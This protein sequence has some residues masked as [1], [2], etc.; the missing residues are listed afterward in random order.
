MTV[1]DDD[2]VRTVLRASGAP[3]VPLTADEVRLLQREIDRRYPGLLSPPDGDT[4]RAVPLVVPPAVATAYELAAYPGFRCVELVQPSG[5][6]HV[7][8]AMVAF[9]DD[10]VLA[11]VLDD[12]GRA[13]DLVDRLAPFHAAD[14]TAVEAYLRFRL[15]S[16]RVGGR[17]YHLAD[18]AGSIAEAFDDGRHDELAVSLV[19]VQDGR[20]PRRATVGL[21][22]RPGEGIVAAALPGEP[23]LVKDEPGAPLVPEH[24]GR[25]ADHAAMRVPTPPFVETWDHTWRPAPPTAASTPD[26]GSGEGV[27]EWAA[28]ADLLAGF[29]IGAD[30]GRRTIIRSLRLPFYRTFRLFEVVAPAPAGEADP[31]LGYCLGRPKPGASSS[32]ELRHLDGTATPIYDANEATDSEPGALVELCLE[33]PA[34]E[35]LIGSAEDRVAGYVAFFCWGIEAAAGQFLVPARLDHLELEAV[36]STELREEVGRRG[37]LPGLR[38]PFGPVDRLGPFARE[39]LVVHGELVA[40]ASFAVDRDGL[41]AM[42]GDEP[43]GVVAA[44]TGSTRAE[45]RLGWDASR[46]GEGARPAPEAPPVVPEP[47]ALEVERHGDAVTFRGGTFDDTT[48][49]LGRLEGVRRATFEG[50]WFPRGLDLRGR[51]VEP[52]VELV[53]CRFGRAEGEGAAVDLSGASF[54]GDLTFHDCHLPGG[55]TGGGAT[56][57]GALQVLSC[58]LV[59][60]PPTSAERFGSRAGNP[61]AGSYRAS[62]ADGAALDLTGVTVHGNLDVGRSVHSWART[63]VARDV[64]LARARVGGDLQLNGVWC[65]GGVDGAGAE[66]GGACVIGGELDADG[67]SC[68]A[69]RADWLAFD[70]VTIRDGGALDLGHARIERDVVIRDTTTGWLVLSRID[71]GGNLTLAGTKVK[72][73]V[74]ARAATVKQFLY[75]GSQVVDELPDRYLECDGDIDLTWASVG[76]LEL[77]GAQVAGEVA[78]I[79]ATLG[80][81]SFRPAVASVPDADGDVRL[82]T[83]SL[84]RLVV[85]ST[86]VSGDVRLNALRIGAPPQSLFACLSQAFDQLGTDGL[87]IESS[88]IEGEVT[89]LPLSRSV[90]EDLRSKL[91]P[92]VLDRD[93]VKELLRE[94]EQSGGRRETAKTILGNV[95]LRATFGS[96]VDLRDVTVCGRLSLAD[97][98]IAG[99]LRLDAHRLTSEGMEHELR[100][101]CTEAD[102]RMLTCEGNV[103]LSGLEVRRVVRHEG[104]ADRFVMSASDSGDL[105]LGDAVIGGRLDLTRKPFEAPDRARVEGLLDMTGVEAGPVT[106][107]GD[108]I[109]AGREGSKVVLERAR[110]RR[111]IVQ[112]PVSRIDL[113]AVEVARWSGD[114][115]HDGNEGDTATAKHLIAIL[116]PMRPLDNGV[117]LAVEEQLRNE[118]RDDDANEVYVALRR[119]LRTEKPR[120]KRA[121]DWFFWGLFRYGTKPTRPL[122]WIVAPLFVVMS[123]V[124]AQPYAVAPS[125]SLV[126][127]QGDPSAGEEP[128][129]CEALFAEGRDRVPRAQERRLA[130]EDVPCDRITPEVLGYDWTWADGLFLAV[131]QSVPVIDLL[132]YQDWEP[133]RRPVVGSV[134]W[135]RADILATLVRVLSWIFI[136][137]SLVAVSARTIRGRRS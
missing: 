97:S 52:A 10:L 82:L 102:L 46:L 7:G 11:H 83:T 40:A 98:T 130:A 34:D 69:L 59:V 26:D 60:T 104:D 124:L 91:S 4:S 23:V 53:R 106:M 55:L 3:E 27:A 12:H 127:V 135:L 67:V 43:V 128:I 29:G 85:R 64:R 13:L 70:D 62:P 87:C 9:P 125:T 115:P 112:A 41:I 116:E 35:Q 84:G 56:V 68:D 65:G 15:A 96:S 90:A 74:D 8:W 119:R 66:V 47:A 75:C 80:S 99:H 32:W 86:V 136:P 132:T 57:A 113:A 50:S 77:S 48:E 78:L 110:L 31:R 33:D 30:D 133:A 39:A 76:A 36:P 108:N 121:W 2:V 89:S 131:R 44:D 20:T 137:I 71:V 114:E 117:W 51:E 38:R 25:D 109:D 14:G 16:L 100:T 101:V 103:D 88:T 93:A 134:P 63:F 73:A 21:T 72:G 107:T 49:L 28:T 58:N 24:R 126:G 81:I 22:I 79:D 129:T 94:L 17:S 120:R 95:T 61:F 122:W 54:G 92:P 118:G 42:T 19:H 37:L 45:N 105:R 111:L 123:I 1:V 6:G 18:D 5:E